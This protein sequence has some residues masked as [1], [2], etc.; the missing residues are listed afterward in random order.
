[1]AGDD[2][3]QRS[4]IREAILDYVHRHP[5]AA[6]TAGGILECWLPRD[7]FDDAPDHIAAVL[8]EMVADCQL[9]RW[10]LPGG[11]VLYAAANVPGLTMEVD[12]HG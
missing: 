6:D 7:G 11:D 8:E 10:Q 9:Q 1:M 12:K 5:H 2:V 4:R 3:A